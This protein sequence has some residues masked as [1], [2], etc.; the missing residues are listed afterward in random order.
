ME[1]PLLSSLPANIESHRWI[2]IPELSSGNCSAKKTI[3][4]VVGT[5]GLAVVGGWLVYRLFRRSFSSPPSF[6]SNCKSQRNGSITRKGPFVPKNRKPTTTGSQA[7]KTST[8]VDSK[9]RLLAKQE[10]EDQTMNGMPSS[11][12]DSNGDYNPRKMSSSSV[13]QHYPR[14]RMR[15]DSLT[16][17]TTL[18]L[19]NRSP[20]DLMLYGLES[21]KRTIRLFEET[22]TKM[23][24]EVEDFG[25]VSRENSPDG[26]LEFILCKSRQLADDVDSYLKE[27]FPGSQDLIGS[28]DGVDCASASVS[29]SRQLLVNGEVSCLDNQGS[30]SNLL[31]SKQDSQFGSNVSLATTMT[32]PFFDIEPNI[33][34]FKL[35]TNALEGLES[36]LETRTDRTNQVKCESHAEYLA[37]VHCLR[38]AFAEL[39]LDEDNADYFCSIGQEILEILMSHSLRDPTE[40]LSAF[41]G[42]LAYVSDASNHAFISEEISQRNIPLVSFYDL[43]LDYILLESF[44][45]LESPPSAVTSV[46]NNRWLSSGFRELALQTAVSAVLK[47]KRN[48]VKVKHGFFD[49]FYDILEHVSPVLAWGFLGSDG[50]LK[51]K[52]N[53]IKDAVLR[54]VRGYFSFDRVRYTSLHDLKEDILRITDDEYDLLRRQLSLTTQGEEDDS[55]ED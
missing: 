3:F 30:L 38:Q 22:Q 40:C 34:F 16:S 20:S 51:F 43:V 4:I 14:R 33:H 17:G 47:H 29:F 55:S 21:L 50:H 37:K 1:T 48:K 44:D 41:D 25:S 19:T 42:M 39:L 24:L 46:A 36:I 32:L 2:K 8:P 27:H 35:Y 23:T 9:A 12:L 49:H 10:S 45:D 7:T 6:P 15:S 54:L 5:T 11:F 31:R 18:L 13:Q 28:H 26:E 52:C 53:L